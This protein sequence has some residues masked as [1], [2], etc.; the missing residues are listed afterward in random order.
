M[1]NGLPSGPP[2][3]PIGNQQ[4]RFNTNIPM[5]ESANPNQ[6]TT[7]LQQFGLTP[8]VGQSTP[9]SRPES[10]QRNQINIPFAHTG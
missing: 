5:N 1:F 2:Q 6:I 9:E 3:S 8:G 4:P 7:I 10:Q